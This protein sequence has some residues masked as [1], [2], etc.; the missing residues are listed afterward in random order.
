MKIFGSA[1]LSAF[2]SPLYINYAGVY[3]S[4]VLDAHL[5]RELVLKNEEG[6]MER[7]WVAYGIRPTY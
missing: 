3:F 2:L 7:E 5:C 4:K 1:C 6:E